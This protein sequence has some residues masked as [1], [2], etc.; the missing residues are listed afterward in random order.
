MNL[1]FRKEVERMGVEELKQ[2]L[3]FI[4]QEQA[5]K[6][7]LT[8]VFRQEV[9]WEREPNKRAVVTGVN[10]TAS[11]ATIFYDGGTQVVPF[12]EIK[13]LP[14]ANRGFMIGEKAI[15][16]D[17]RHLRWLITYILDDDCGQR[18]LEVKNSYGHWACVEREYLTHTEI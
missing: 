11:Q 4:R 12:T 16:W 18:S 3:E 13:H 7:N 8:F 9:V 14:P 5:R 10:K 15:M 17:E 6:A 2:A 1:T